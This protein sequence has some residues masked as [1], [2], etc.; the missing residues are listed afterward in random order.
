MIIVTKQNTKIYL[1][2][3]SPEYF[4]YLH[5]LNKLN[6]NDLGSHGFSSI[7]LNFSNVNGGIGVVGGYQIS[8]TEWLNNLHR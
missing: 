8:E 5:A 3:L 4:K 2:A 1:Y 6:S 7:P